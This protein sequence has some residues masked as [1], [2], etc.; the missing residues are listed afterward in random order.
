MSE[1]EFDRKKLSAMPGLIS[2]FDAQK[3]EFIPTFTE[4]AADNFV[5]SDKLPLD[6]V[7]SGS[8][9]FY[10]GWLKTGREISMIS[11]EPAVS[12]GT[13]VKLDPNIAIKRILIE[14]RNEY[15]VLELERV[16][17]CAYR[18]PGLRRP[19]D[20]PQM[21]MN[22]TS[23]MRIFKQGQRFAPQ[24]QRIHDLRAAR[25]KLNIQG[26][27]DV[28][29]ATIK[30]DAAPLQY[31]GMQFTSDMRKL[32]PTEQIVENYFADAK[33]VGFELQAFFSVKKQIA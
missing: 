32:I 20:D 13:E 24:Y 5:V 30:V 16:P 26:L 25:V 2:V 19:T 29:A 28:N 11:L 14:A 7:Y 8:S 23:K 12:G 27:I 6:A 33:V 9:S 15:L 1:K 17:G 10:T 31:K 22:F 4:A 18:Y 21:V 3:V